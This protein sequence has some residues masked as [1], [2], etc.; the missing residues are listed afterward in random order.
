MGLFI[1]LGIATVI[2]ACIG[3]WGLIQL[4]KERKTAH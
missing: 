4:R 3:I 1:F 2:A